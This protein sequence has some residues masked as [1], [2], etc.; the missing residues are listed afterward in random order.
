[1]II[2]ELIDELSKYDSSIEVVVS[3]GYGTIDP[4]LKISVEKVNN[5]DDIVSVY[6]LDDVTNV[7]V[8][9]WNH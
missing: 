1:M 4:I 8:L 2:K 9:G 3:D 7:L 5:C 6:W